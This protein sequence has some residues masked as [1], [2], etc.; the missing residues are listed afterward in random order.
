[1]CSNAIGPLV[2]VWLIATL[3]VVEK[4]TRTPIWILLYG[5]VGISVGLWVLGRRVIKTM[6]EDLTKVTP[7][8]SVIPQAIHSNL[9]C[10]TQVDSKM[11]L[12]VLFREGSIVKVFIHTNVLHYFLQRLLYRDRIGLDRARSVQHWTADQHH[13]L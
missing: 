4:A 2:S 6:G 7:S 13:A 12:L 11:P 10:R 1:M 8:R 3:G 5:G 9:V